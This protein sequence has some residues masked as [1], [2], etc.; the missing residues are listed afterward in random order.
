MELIGHADSAA[1]IKC[2]VNTFE[3]L[4]AV[5]RRCLNNN[6]KVVNLG[7]GKQYGTSKA[8]LLYGMHFEG[9]AVP[10]SPGLDQ[11]ERTKR[12]KYVKGSKYPSMRFI[13][14][15]LNRQGPEWCEKV[16]ILRVL[17]TTNRVPLEMLAGVRPH[18]RQLGGLS[19]RAPSLEEGRMVARDGAV[20]RERSLC[21]V[22]W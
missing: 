2:Y 3:H 20:S 15:E 5:P 14:A 1:F 4:G 13:A 8:R 22:L 10:T 21:C 6:A 9:A 19:N 18:M 12:V 16:D 17:G 11:G 7:R